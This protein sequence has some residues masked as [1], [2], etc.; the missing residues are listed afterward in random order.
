M[1]NAPP[2]RD[3]VQSASHTAKGCS[4]DVLVIILVEAEEEGGQ[5]YTWEGFCPLAAPLTTIASAW[6]H[7]HSVPVHAVAFEEES[8]E[9]VDQSK[10]PSDYGWTEDQQVRLKCYPAS[11]EF[12]EAEGDDASSEL[13]QPP[14]VQTKGADAVASQPRVT[15]PAA[16]KATVGSPTAVEAKGIKR[17]ATKDATPEIEIKKKN[18]RGFTASFQ[19]RSDPCCKVIWRQARQ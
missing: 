7:K 2:E 4:D 14:A 16:K 6:A 12:A 10:T 1:A 5:L 11:D 18:S 3:L 15:K 9:E 8:G 13:Q 19:R 17:E